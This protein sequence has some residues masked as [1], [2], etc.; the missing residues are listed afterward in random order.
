VESFHAEFCSEER[1][2]HSTITSST[3]MER[4]S[5]KK[6]EY[7]KWG[8]EIQD[9]NDAKM[10]PGCCPPL[11]PDMPADLRASY[12]AKYAAILPNMSES[13]VMAFYAC[14]NRK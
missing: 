10:Y 8:D 12:E 1:A 13:D 11:P 7:R 2:E 3:R 9:D 6:I 14:V 4:Q 5:T